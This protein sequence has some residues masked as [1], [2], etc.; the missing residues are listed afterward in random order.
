MSP[1]TP[2]LLIQQIIP[3]DLS[4]YA[5]IPIAFE[6]RSVLEVEPI[7]R[8][9][10]GGVRL[11]ERPVR[12][13]YTKDYDAQEDGG[14]ERWADQH[15]LSK[16]AIF[17]AVTDGRPVGGATVALD[18]PN[19]SGFHNSRDVAGLW[20]FR[21]HPGFRR[22]GVGTALFDRVVEAARL[23][24]C[25]RLKIETQSI[26]VPACRFY[27]SQGCTLGGLDVHAYGSDPACAHETMLLWY[28][29]LQA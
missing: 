12:E 16:W 15:D 22:Q 13:P 27:A 11:A 25:P 9:G 14:P 29:D 21:V 8:G 7:D 17:L 3:D 1:G 4:T 10:L 26:N 19:I 5:S 2:N 24:G 28:L 6:V 20:D 23:H 18:T